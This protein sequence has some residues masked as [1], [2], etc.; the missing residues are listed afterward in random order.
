MEVK[1]MKTMFTLNATDVRQNWSAI[2]ECAVREKPQFIKR[3]RDYMVLADIKFLEELLAAYHFTAD[4]FNE[5][6]GSVT[7]SL[8]ELDLVENSKTEDEAK[9]LLGHSILEYA[10]DYYSEFN[11]W[12]SAP[13]RKGHIPYVLKALIINDA[14]KIGDIIECQAGKI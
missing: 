7:L 13:N 3:T 4:R 14:K 6:D 1:E 5:D 8:K 11:L 2:M 12:N 9:L 10:E